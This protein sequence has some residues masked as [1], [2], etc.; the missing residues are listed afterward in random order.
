MSTIKQGVT[1]LFIVVF[2]LW[3][4]TTGLDA[5]LKLPRISPNGELGQTIGTTVI[6]ADY[7]RPGVKGR[8]IWGKLVPYNEVWRAGANDATMISFSSDVSIDGKKLAAG[9]YSFF[10]LPTTN[11]WTFI[12]NGEPKQWGAFNYK[13]EKDVLRSEEHT[14][15]LQSQR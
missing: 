4:F 14:S 15:E 2:A 3:A 1:L 8:E 5:Q 10:I 13:K 11:E 12:F 9:T 6:K 7:S